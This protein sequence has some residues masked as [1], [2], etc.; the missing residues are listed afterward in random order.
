MARQA[1]SLLSA[2]RL[3]LGSEALPSSFPP[4]AGTEATLAPAR[5]AAVIKATPVLQTLEQ[6][7][8][9]LRLKRNLAQNDLRPELDFSLKLAKD[10]GQGPRTLNGNDVITGFE[11]SLPLQ[12]RKARGAGEEAEAALQAVTY[13]QALEMDALRLA[14]IRLQET[15]AAAADFA[16]LADQEAEAAKTLEAAEWVRF[17]EGASSFFILNAREE[18]TADAQVRAL[19]AQLAFQQAMADF[20]LV[21]ADRARL[22]LAPLPPMEA[23]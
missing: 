10:L 18:N 13:R 6:R 19:D 21:T 4:I 14:I 11:F 16:A 23:P 20:A 8:R 7:S 12:R 9:R 3:L 17:H 15:V 22:G 1:P 2:L 5:L